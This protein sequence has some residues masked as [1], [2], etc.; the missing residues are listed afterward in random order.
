MD[1]EF[2]VL[3]MME[4]H[5]N[6]E[7]TAEYTIQE[8]IKRLFFCTI[9]IN[10][11][12]MRVHLVKHNWTSI[13]KPLLQWENSFSF[14]CLFNIFAEIAT[15]FC[16]KWRMIWKYFWNEGL[17]SVGGQKVRRRTELL[18]W[19]WRKVYCKIRLFKIQALFV[20]G[21]W[22]RAPILQS[23]VSTKPKKRN[24]CNRFPAQISSRNTGNFSSDARPAFCR[25]RFPS[26]KSS[27]FTGLPMKRR[28]YV[29]L[30]RKFSTF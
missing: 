20:S 24:S 7:R 18:C 26:E 17:P 14:R 25:Q 16:P 1:I 30:K 23:S 12:H 15:S 13:I 4:Y 19:N 9:R 28:E 6:K 8:S 29:S 27:K 11:I 5:F 21:C 2:T 10:I 22:G 3:S